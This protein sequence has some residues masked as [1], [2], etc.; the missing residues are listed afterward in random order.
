L[1]FRRA[2]VEL[3]ALARS[4]VRVRGVLDDRFG[5]RIE[6]TDPAMIELL[7]KDTGRGG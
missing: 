6:V 2:G 4:R 7:E 3:G 5:P 1:E